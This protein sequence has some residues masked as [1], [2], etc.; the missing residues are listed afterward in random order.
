ML[1]KRKLKRQRSGVPLFSL[2][3]MQ[4]CSIGTTTESVRGMKWYSYQEWITAAE[5]DGISRA[6]AH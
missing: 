1:C 6:K 2:Q 3:A 5:G 4:S